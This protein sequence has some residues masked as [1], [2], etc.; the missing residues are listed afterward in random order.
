MPGNFSDQP[1][2]KQARSPNPLGPGGADGKGPPSVADL[3]PRFPHLELLDL[4]GVGGMGAVYRA[5][6]KSLDRIVAL[7]ILPPHPDRHESFAERFTREARALARLQHANIVTIYDSGSLDDLYYFIMEFVDGSNLR[8]TLVAGEGRVQSDSARNIVSAVCDALDYAHAEGIAHR[9]IKP[10]NILIDRKGRVKIADFGIAK[11]LQRPDT[12]Y[13]L[14]HTQQIIGTMHYMAPE[15]IEKPTTVDHRADIY[16]LG[17]VLYEMITGELPIGRFPL[18]SER[19]AQDAWLD[20]IVLRALEKEPSR[21][22]QR[23]SEIKTDLLRLGSP[24][25][26]MPQSAFG[27]AATMQQQ[28]NTPPVPHPMASTEGPAWRR[29]NALTPK[30]ASSIGNPTPF[31]VSAE[32]PTPMQAALAPFAAP[33]PGMRSEGLGYLCWI[34]C[35]VGCN[36][37]HRM[38]AGKWI[39]GF[40]WFFTLGFLYIGQVI[41]LF[42]IPGMIRKANA[43]IRR[44]MGLLHAPQPAA[45]SNDHTTQSR[46]LRTIFMVVAIIALLVLIVA[47]FTMILMPRIAQP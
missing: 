3:A 10:E 5:R 31:P 6:Q 33:M 21:R 13:T 34:A 11:L 24:A 15:Q 37:I 16:S 26:A 40:L 14:T 27:F 25:S 19:I 44:E 42:L 8:Q 41:D 43:R 28:S 1:T 46:W 20:Q 23:A 39:T 35:L 36:G 18:P 12:Q 45:M 4:I 22:Y 7:K 30:P 9:D 47:V 38:Y 29:G 17:V 32:T 2:L